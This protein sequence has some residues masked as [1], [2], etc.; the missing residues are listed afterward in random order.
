MRTNTAS[1]KAM[2]GQYLTW[3]VNEFLVIYST[4]YYES[5]GLGYIWGYKKYKHSAVAPSVIKL[6]LHS[7]SDSPPQ[8]RSSQAN[9]AQSAGTVWQQTN[10]APR[11]CKCILNLTLLYLIFNVT[12]FLFNQL[13]FPWGGEF[14]PAW[15]T[16]AALTPG[17][18]AHD[19]WVGPGLCISDLATSHKSF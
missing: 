12:I 4:P 6:T 7:E 19:V 11:L 9:I 1:K 17:H 3:I 18:C 15:N 2:T 5:T 8:T 10:T 13:C 16:W 14:V